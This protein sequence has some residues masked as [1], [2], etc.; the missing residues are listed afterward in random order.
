MTW[1]WQR[2]ERVRRVLFDVGVGQVGGAD[3]WPHRADA[4]V[5]GDVDVV[6]GQVHLAGARRADAVD[7]DRG[8]V[9]RHAD[10]V[11][12]EFTGAMPTAAS[13][14][15]QF[16]SEPN[17]AVLTRLSRAM[18]RAAATASSSVAAPV[19][20]MATRLVTPSASACNCAQRSSHTR[21]TASSNSAWLGVISLA[22]DASSSTVSLV[23]QLPSTSRRSK[24]CA[25]ARAAHGRARRHRRPRRW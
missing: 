25:V 9:E 14:R 6:A 12:V 4:E 24:V 3:G 18:T 1:R 16:G 2:H 23:E 21:S 8:T 7:A 10:P 17:S 19:T 5:D 20:V 15:P 11:W 22:P 13:T